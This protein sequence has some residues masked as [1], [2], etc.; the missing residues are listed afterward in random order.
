MP[1]YS[2][3]CELSLRMCS[4]PTLRAPY[5]TLAVTDADLP[6]GDDV[7]DAAQVWMQKEAHSVLAPVDAVVGYGRVC[8]VDMKRY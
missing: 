6:V 8:V 3:H 7:F 2:S 1:V 5:T 4:N